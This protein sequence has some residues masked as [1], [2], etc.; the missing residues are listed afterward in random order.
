MA[1]TTEAKTSS[2]Q[3]KST[4]SASGER[5]ESSFARTT[6][7][8]VIGALLFAAAAAWYFF[9]FVPTKLDYFVGLRF[10][11]LAVASGHVA[12]KIDGLARA[13][14][15]VPPPPGIPPKAECGTPTPEVRTDRAK[16]VALVLP[17]IQ[18]SPAGRGPQGPAFSACDVSG[19]VAWADVAVQAAAASRRDFD[20][21]VIADAG[22]DVVWQREISTA[23]IGNLSELLGA[24]EDAGGFWS[25]SWRERATML[26]KKDAANLRS[27]AVLKVVNLDGSSS[28]LLV[29]AVPLT[30]RS[31]I[32]AGSQADKTGPPRL[33]VAGLLSR[34]AL[35]QQARRIP[36]AW[37]VLI[38]LPIMV[39]FLAIPFVKL[40]TLTIKE[41][42]RFTDLVL[43]I[44][45]TVVGAG[46]GAM[47]PF[48]AAPAGAPDAKLARLAQAINN[49]LKEETR[50]VLQLADTILDN[51]EPIEEKLKLCG[52]LGSGLPTTTKD[53]LGKNACE[54][55]QAFDEVV[56]PAEK[57]GLS[58]ELDV[59]IWKRSW[60]MRSRGQTSSTSWTSY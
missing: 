5:E 26:G 11:T 42:Y 55:W 43:M 38:A 44:L 58:I 19:S 59:V 52:A 2:E 15:S 49:N 1:D 54:L 32:L 48:V 23:R 56:P 53:P 46:L 20:D 37:V 35:Q 31:I 33:Y 16:Y 50:E 47:I 45:A 60:S 34:A 57:A 12:S 14:G 29:Q 40:A 6:L 17:E 22:G 30:D 21:L 3:S 28:V 24:P 7:P 4:P 13:L 18:L 51:R 25:L 9:V 39:L 27:S 8:Y 41:R 10:R 36:A